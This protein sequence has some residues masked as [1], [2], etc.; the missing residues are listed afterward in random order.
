MTDALLL[1]LLIVLSLGGVV[2]AVLQ[3][4]G[5]WLILIAA[6]GYDWWYGWDRLGWRWLA[7]LAGVA[8]AAEIVD[9]LAAM[10][11]VKR[12]GASRRATIGALVG[13]FAGMLLLSVPVPVL[14][15]VIGG[16]AGCFAGAVIGELSVR[17]DLSAS[18]RV[19]LFA[20]LGRAAGLMI[21]TAAAI[22]VA[23]VAVSLAAR[24]AW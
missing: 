10:V 16:I 14:G 24:A 13:G 9:A 22:G 20:A 12:A 23:G 11:A 4:P 2:L 6:A 15:T 5:V 18:A 7:A 21:K 3:L 17:D 1:I 8:V 19:G